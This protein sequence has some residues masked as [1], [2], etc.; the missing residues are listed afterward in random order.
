MQ[1]LEGNTFRRIVVALDGSE[2]AEQ[3]LPVVSPI[4]RAFDSSVTLLRAVDPV[5]PPIIWGDMS[6]HVAS[7]VPYEDLLQAARQEQTD[8]ATYLVEQ[9]KQ[10]QDVG[11]TV[12]SERLEGSAAETIL[13]YARNERA[14]LIGLTTHGRGG[15]GRVVFG[16]VAEAVLRASPCPVL[17]VRV[18]ED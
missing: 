8:A 14:N 7:G 15:L 5:Q 2:R 1:E 18:Q 12:N 3:I 16:S 4:A 6:G 9:Q 17:L 11:L 13:E 10:L